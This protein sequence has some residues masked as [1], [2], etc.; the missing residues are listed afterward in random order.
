MCGRTRLGHRPPEV[1][2]TTI[3]T[4]KLVQGHGVE[5]PQ[6]LN[7]Q[8]FFIKNLSENVKNARAPHR[9]IG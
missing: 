9:Y 4:A 1:K 2:N 7:R 5:T 8:N 3:L 6:D